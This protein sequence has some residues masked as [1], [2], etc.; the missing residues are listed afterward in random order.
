MNTPNAR[1]LKARHLALGLTLAATALAGT[2]WADQATK[3]PAPPAE[4]TRA[5]A[6][7]RAMAAF[8]QADVNKDGKLDRADFEARRE[9]RRT[10]MFDRLDTD[11]NGQLSRAEFTATPRGPEGREGWGHGRRRDGEREPGRG[12]GHHF[13]H[14]GPGG[15]GGPDGPGGPTRFADGNKDGA[16]SQG[17]FVAAALQRFD[18]MD[19]NKDGKVTAQERQAARDARRAQWGKQGGHDMPPPPPPPPAS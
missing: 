1:R 6:Q 13:G 11:K 7:N 4:I 5:E 16:V 18:S 17:E 19:A 15:H 2:A 10:A 3:R 9:A 8:T 14:R 12:P